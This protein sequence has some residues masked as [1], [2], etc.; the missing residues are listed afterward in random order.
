MNQVSLAPQTKTSTIGPHCLSNLI[1][2]LNLDDDLN[3]LNT[4]GLLT[5]FPIGSYREVFICLANHDNALKM[6]HHKFAHEAI[7]LTPTLISS[8]IDRLFLLINQLVFLIGLIGEGELI[9]V[10]VNSNQIANFI[11]KTNL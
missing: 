7:L 6:L 3:P 4:S 9:I 5:P 10:N 8:I 11:S 1:V 2:V